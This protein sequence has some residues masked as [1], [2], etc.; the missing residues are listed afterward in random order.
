MIVRG[1]EK[2]NGIVP[3]RQFCAPYLIL[4][5]FHI[6]TA[7]CTIQC[8]QMSNYDATRTQRDI[9]LLHL[10]SREHLTSLGSTYYYRYVAKVTSHQFLMEIFSGKLMRWILQ[11]PDR[12]KCVFQFD[13]HFSCVAQMAVH[14]TS[15][16]S[17]QAGEIWCSV[18]HVQLGIQL[19]ILVSLEHFCTLCM[20]LGHSEVPWR[21]EHATSPVC[22]VQLGCRG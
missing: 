4:H 9:T 16:P 15:I 21:L 17:T 3:F 8:A 20:V 1:W 22:H 11:T 14:R 6:I 5:A 7:R 13:T 18:C 12:K 10:L 19:H 2:L